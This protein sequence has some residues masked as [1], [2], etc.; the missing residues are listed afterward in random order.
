MK[1]L[2]EDHQCLWIEPVASIFRGEDSYME[3]RRQ[4]KSLRKGGADTIK[5]FLKR[6]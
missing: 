2:S 6:G 4:K 1:N 5:K 3:F